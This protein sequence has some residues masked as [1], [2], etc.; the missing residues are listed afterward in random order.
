MQTRQPTES[1]LLNI[2]QIILTLA[3]YHIKWH[4]CVAR[5]LKLQTNLREDFTI[6]I[7]YINYIFCVTLISDIIALVSVG[8]PFLCLITVG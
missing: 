2:A 1:V 8:V 7:E 3:F 6:T 5:I 4:D